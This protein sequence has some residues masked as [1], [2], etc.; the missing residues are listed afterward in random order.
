MSF[1]LWGGGDGVRMQELLKLTKKPTD[2]QTLQKI[3]PSVRGHTE[4]DGNF[5]SSLHTFIE[6]TLQIRP[7]LDK[8]M[9]A[10]PKNATLYD[11]EKSK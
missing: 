8:F 2:E 10:C 3:N 1:Y 5:Q 4:A 6:F 9:S 7:D 11:V